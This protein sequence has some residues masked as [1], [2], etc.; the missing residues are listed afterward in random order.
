MAQRLGSGVDIYVCSRTTPR[1]L[2]R[3]RNLKGFIIDDKVLYSGA[4]LNDVL[5]ATAPALSP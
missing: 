2:G 5:P 4:S 3:R 1:V